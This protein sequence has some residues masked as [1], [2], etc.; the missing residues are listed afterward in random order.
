MACQQ[1]THAAEKS[2]LERNKISLPIKK[3]LVFALMH[4]ELKEIGA[5]KVDWLIDKISTLLHEQIGSKES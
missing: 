1:S 5:P 2:F 3:D 4:E